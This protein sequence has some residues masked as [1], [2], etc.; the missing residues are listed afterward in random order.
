MPNGFKKLYNAQLANLRA[1]AFDYTNYTANTNWQDLVL[2]DAVITSNNLSISNNTEKSTTYLN[3]GYTNQ[4]GV[5]RN[6]N[7]TRYLARINE[8]IRFTDKIKVGGEVTGYH[9]VAN[10]PS[11][12]ISNALWAAPI[13]PIQQDANTY[14]SMPS[15]QRAQVGN[16]IAALNR[17][18]GTNIDKGFRIIGNLF[19]EIKFAQY[20][21]WRSTF[22]T[23][24]AFNNNRSF[25]RL[26]YT[27]INLGEG[28]TPTTTTFD[29]SVRTSVSQSQSESKRYQQDHTLILQDP[30]TT[31]RSLRWQVLLLFTVIV[32]ISM[33][34]A[35]I[36]LLTSTTIP[37]SGTSVYP[38]QTTRVILMAAAEKALSK[39]TSEE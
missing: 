18:D 26:P 4:D 39:V 14:Y 7:Y 20:F 16:P 8:E 5:L 37:I 19:A 32:L 33:Q 10:A 25:S 24:L 28:T 36:P 2:R 15:F 11:A 13:V 23:D 6:D 22:Y 34:H 1:P 27:F 38:M 30:S 31:I 17:G 9:W 21:T 12:S 35:G 29:N 3:I